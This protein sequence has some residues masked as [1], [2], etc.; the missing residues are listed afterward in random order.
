LLSSRLG[1]ATRKAKGGTRQLRKINGALKAMDEPVKRKDGQFLMCNEF[2]IAVIAT[3]AILSM[4]STADP[5]P[6]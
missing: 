2:S 6:S 3:G 4:I 1:E 5:I